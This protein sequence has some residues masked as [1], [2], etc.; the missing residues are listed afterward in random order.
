MCVCVCVF[1]FRANDQVF[2]RSTMLRSFIAV[3][4]GAADGGDDDDNNG[5]LSSTSP[6]PSIPLPS[7]YLF[8][9]FLLGSVIAFVVV[10]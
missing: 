7:F 8:L 10:T 6:P 9:T 3:C 4:G 1:G 2:M 5:L